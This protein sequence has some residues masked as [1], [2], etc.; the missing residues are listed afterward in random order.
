[1]EFKKQKAIYLQIADSLCHRVVAGEWQPGGRIPSVREVAAEL[2][3]N[4][5]TVLRTFEHLQGAE[6]IEMRRGLGAFVTTD[7]VEKIL[8]EQRRHFLEEEWP[9]VCRRMRML[10]L[11][12][13][14]LEKAEPAE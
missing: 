4:P 6:I 1:M 5:N 9:D 11:T 13:S 14:D 7:A 10:G 3:V 12:L 8:R 2:G